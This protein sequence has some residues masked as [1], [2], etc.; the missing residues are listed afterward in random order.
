M[1][2][3]GVTRQSAALIAPP[4]RP[5]EKNL[6]YGLGFLFQVAPRKAGVFVN[7]ELTGTT[8]YGFLNGNDVVLFDDLATISS[9][10]FFPAT[11]NEYP[12]TNTLLL[13]SPMV[14]GFIPLQAKNKTNS[15]HPHVGTGF[16]IAQ[17]HRF[18]LNDAGE[19]SWVDPDRRD[20]LEVFQLSWDGRQFDVR[21]SGTFTQGSDSPL[22]IK[23]TPWFIYSHGM[24]NAVPDGDD[25]LL[26]V[27][28]ANIDSALTAVGVARW[29]SLNGVWMPVAFDLVAEGG[30]PEPGPNLV[31][32]SLW[33]EPSLVRDA[34]GNLLFCARGQDEG[35]TPDKI[36]MGNLVRVWQSGDQ[37]KTWRV[38]LTAPNIR[39]LAPVTVNCAADGTLYIV[40]NPFI[41]NFTP[42]PKTGRGRNTLCL[43]PLNPVRTGLET[44]LLIRDAVAEFGP[45][46]ASCDLER[47]ETWMLDHP[48]A[49][50]VQLADD[51]W[52]N[53]LAYRVKHS[54]LWAAAATQPAPQT[55]CYLEEIF[56]SGPAVQAWEFMD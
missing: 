51:R 49:A 3:T 19:F 2:I 38:L 11:R 23:N 16:G 27:A 40:S 30:S 46:P 34:A 32:R 18:P 20:L 7:L 4:H 37:G 39:N 44:P 26:P 22:R 1:A 24:T 50:T 42:T 36:A 41:P 12:E 5:E 13:K 6:R 17:A 47:P 33:W 56:S 45:P 43:W 52:H 55:G 25:L 54:P 21:R 53:L 9:G 14:G 28:A 8:A 10:Q 48:T 35:Y 31:E 15:L 29:R